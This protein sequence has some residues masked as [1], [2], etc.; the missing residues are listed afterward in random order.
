MWPYRHLQLLFEF[1]R[2]TISHN[3]EPPIFCER[4]LE[5]LSAIKQQCRLSAYYN[6][7]NATASDSEE[8]CSTCTMSNED[9]SASPAAPAPADS[10]APARTHSAAFLCKLAC[11][12]LSESIKCAAL[13]S[14][15]LLPKHMHVFAARQ[16]STQHH[17]DATVR[18]CPLKT[19]RCNA[20]MDHFADLPAFSQS[21]LHRGERARSGRWGDY[22]TQQRGWFTL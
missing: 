20:C 10:A 18:S 6:E 2:R 1:E 9:V 19:Q 11:L 21:S 13:S 15:L 3:P 14:H 17:A 12:S 5:L 22:R 8:R 4:Q 16:L 7:H